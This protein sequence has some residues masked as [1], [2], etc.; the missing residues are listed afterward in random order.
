MSKLLDKGQKKKIH[1][2]QIFKKVDYRSW[3]PVNQ[4]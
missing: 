2:M 1:T 3:R 4:A